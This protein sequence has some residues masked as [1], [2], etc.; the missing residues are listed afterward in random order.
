MTQAWDKTLRARGYRVTP[1]RQLVLAAVTKLEHATPEEIWADVQQT[2]STQGCN[3]IQSKK[4]AAMLLLMWTGR[5]DP[6]ITYTQMMG[7]DRLLPNSA[8]NLAK[9]DYGADELLKQLNATF[10]QAEQ[11]K[12]YDK[13][14]AVFVDEYSFMPLYSFV[15]VCEALDLAHEPLRRALL[16][17]R[18]RVRA[19]RRSPAARRRLLAGKEPMVFADSA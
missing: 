8:F 13:L 3:E 7:S 5:P 17:W 2:A 9:R 4:G 18:W 14:N 11:K 12:I 15:N 10:D 1:Q 16:D 6:A 19:A